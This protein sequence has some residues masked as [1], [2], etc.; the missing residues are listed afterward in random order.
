MAGFDWGDLRYF[1]AVARTGRLTAAARQLRVDHAT[2]ARRLAALESALGAKLF[3]RTP[4]G[5]RLTGAGERMMATAETMETRAMAIE[6]EIAGIDMAV[7]GTVRLGAP[8]G[9][10]T[11][12]LA[13]RLP[14]LLERHPQLVVQLVPLPRAFSLAKREA[15]LVVAIDLPE[16]SRLSVEHL[17][18][19]T[20]G[21][22]ASPDYLK[23]H[24]PIRSAADLERHRVVTYVPDLLY[25]EALDY[26]GE[27][28]IPETQRFECA[29]VIGQMEAVI[30]GAGVGVLHDYA[31]AGHPSLRQVLPVRARRAYWL[32][33]HREV[34]GLARIACVRDFIVEAVA[35]ERRMFVFG[36]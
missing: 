10:G 15:D 4:Q 34:Q 36:S 29:S 16:R 2:V 19:Y 33:G 26:L 18:D 31:A 20:L 17:T 3:E 5:Y 22:Y 23:A 21:L 32:A 25:S 1:L 27:F 7:S 8:D 14:A 28:A 12:F 30:A 11:Y 24:P 6:G 13:R 9:F 35:A